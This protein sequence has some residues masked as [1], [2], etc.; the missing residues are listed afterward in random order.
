MLKSDK[1]SISGNIITM[2]DKNP[3]ATT[4]ATLNNKILYIGNE[5]GIKEFIDN[6]TKIFDLKEKTV[7]PGLHNNHIHS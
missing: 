5:D 4:I 6:D 7:L 3:K 1:S 2:E